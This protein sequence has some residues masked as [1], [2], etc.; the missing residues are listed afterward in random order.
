M[1][2]RLLGRLYR[3]LLRLQP[4][5]VRRRYGAEMEALFRQRVR[6]GAAMRELADA[7]RPAAG[8]LFA[9]GATLHA[10]YAACVFPDATMGISAILLT[11]AFL[12]AGVALIRRE[13]KAAAD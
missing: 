1:R 9:G 10:I 4:R 13:L 2:V 12:L 6:D 7:G 5:E 3:L 11:A 8:W